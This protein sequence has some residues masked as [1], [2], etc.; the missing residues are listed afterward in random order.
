MQA[1]NAVLLL[2]PSI[3]DGKP[4]LVALTPG[5]V[6]ETLNGAGGFHI[7][8]VRLLTELL[9]QDLQAH[10][11]CDLSEADIRNI[12]TAASLHDIGNTALP[13]ALLDFSG[14]YSAMQYDIV[15]QHARRGAQII[16]NA[17]FS[18][19]PAGMKDHA[20]AIARYHHE[21]YDGTG[22]PDG[23]VGDDIPLSAQVVAVADAYDALTGVHK[24]AYSQDVAIQMITS[25]MCGVFNEAILES[26]L[27][28]VD[29]TE[30]QK[31]RETLDRS[32][33]VVADNVDDTPERVLCIGNTAYLT[34]AFI[35]DTFPESKVTVVGNTTLK[36]G[37]RIKLF[38]MK[39]LSVKRLF[40]TYEF[41]AVVYFSGDL[42][43]HT[44]EKNDAELL[45]EVLECAEETGKA[46][47]VLFL[48]S[49]DAAFAE[50]T[51]RAILSAAKEN[52]CAFYAGSTQLDIKILQIPYLYSGTSEK[53]F[54]YRVFASAHGGEPVTPETAPQGTAHFIS[55]TDL[56]AL[57]NRIV[58]NWHSGG[59][60]LAVKDDFGLTFADFRKEILQ[61]CPGAQLQFTGREPVGTVR[62][63]NKSLR[64]DYG[65]FARIAPAEE[66]REEYEKFC[67][68][69]EK[70]AATV[71]EKIRSWVGKHSLPVKIAELLL[72]FL[73]TE[74]LVRLTGSAVLFSIV[75]FRMA[76]VVIMATV[77]G[78]NFGLA[79][80]ALSSI[81]WLVAKVRLG[82]SL[83]TL[84]YEPT[85]WLSFVFF[86]L[87][88]ALC[89]YVKLRKDDN[90]RF[91]EQ[92]NTLLE[93][94]LTFT[95]ELYRDTYREKRE[96]KKQIIGAKDSFG[97]IFDIT[98]RLDTVE[99]QEL[100]LQIV[101]VFEEV[102][103][104]K[105]VTVYFMEDEGF[106]RLEVASRDIMG[107]VSRS[108][109]AQTYREVIE[110]TRG[111]EIWRNTA[112]KPDLP[113]YAAGVYRGEKLE[114][115][116]F[117]WQAQPEQRSLYYVN[118]F[119]ILRDLVQMSLLRA[120][121]YNRAVRDEQFVDNT[122][123]MQ[124]AAF[125]NVVGDLAVRAEKKVTNFALVQLDTKGMSYRQVSALLDKKVWDND[126]LGLDDNGNVQVL[127]LQATQKD[128]PPILERLHDLGIGT[129]VLK[130]TG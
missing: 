12:A 105:S 110:H 90:I 87:V 11:L 81:S 21:R 125:A 57:L 95:R 34:D 18:A 35:R 2:D 94:K 1:E 102:L 76:Y 3:P 20:V 16:E 72:L 115:L 50:K 4:E 96:L 32:R 74:L 41:D 47:R 98:R 88:G 120:I 54:L 37:Q 65:W 118:L 53:D 70:Q 126:F 103:E 85:N 69:R 40:E 25:G 13:K 89:G 123:I 122:R 9:L 130:T 29:H 38:P 75:D 15:K 108:I 42:T 14:R 59:G 99:P 26:L 119:K 67:A 86:F 101:E 84:F 111:G 83:L 23:L 28:V 77:H 58:E 73:L 124:P 61:V 80:A 78:L 49:L 71:W 48:S 22:Y 63:D 106:G 19:L 31:L 107:N 112:L 66:L 33:S 6:P 52:L 46:I 44:G 27:R 10:G 127:L 45:R 17:D 114:L 121:A 92:Q 64:K 7:Y 93:E 117:L 62:S 100:Y 24:A 36:G 116:L 109:S 91:V 104:N 56:S 97:K 51:D 68:I 39:K 43:Y 113:M 5:S 79:A 128:L 30:L 55:L 8:H 82:T 60:I 129:T